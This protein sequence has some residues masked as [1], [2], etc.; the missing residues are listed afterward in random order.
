[1]EGKFKFIYIEFFPQLQPT[2]T[3]Y[4][5]VTG[6]VEDKR[7]GCA[8]NCWPESWLGIEFGGVTIMIRNEKYKDLLT[9]YFWRSAS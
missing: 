1:M 7:G 9:E 5:V 6:G 4:K 8:V 2:T 3:A